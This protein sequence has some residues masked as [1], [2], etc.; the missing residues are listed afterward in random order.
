MYS[1]EVN[2]PIQGL[3]LQGSPYRG[4]DIYGSRTAHPD[5]GRRCSEKEKQARENAPPYWENAGKSPVIF[6]KKSYYHFGEVSGRLL[7]KVNL[8][9]FIE[10]N[11]SLEWGAHPVAGSAWFE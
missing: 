7:G 6:L 3:N 4:S 1:P 9:F 5:K 8:Q 2:I 11:N 10:Q